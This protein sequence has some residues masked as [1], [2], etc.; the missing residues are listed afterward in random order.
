MRGRVGLLV[1]GGGGTRCGLLGRGLRGVGATLGGGRGVCYAKWVHGR[2]ASL[3]GAAWGVLG[4]LVA[5][6]GGDTPGALGHLSLSK[7]NTPYRI[8]L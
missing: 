7:E 4:G 2:R 3:Q 6:H 1:R 5:G 8:H